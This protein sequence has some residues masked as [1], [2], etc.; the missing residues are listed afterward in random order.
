MDNKQLDLIAKEVS[1]ILSTKK[2]AKGNRAV[3]FVEVIFE[4]MYR[5][6]S[7]VYNNIKLLIILGVIFTI[8][9]GL[10]VFVLYSI[11]ETAVVIKDVV[12]GIQIAINEVI[13]GINIISNTLST[14]ASDVSSAIG[15]GGVNIPTIPKVD[16]L[17]S[18]SFLQTMFKLVTECKS[19]NNV[20]DELM[21]L[22][23]AVSED[24][25]CAYACTTQ[26]IY[27]VQHSI[28][29]IINFLIVNDCTKLISRIF[30]CIIDI[31]MLVLFYIIFIIVKIIVYSSI[32]LLLYIYNYYIYPFINYIRMEILRH[33]KLQHYLQQPSY[34]HTKS[35]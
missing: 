1:I 22:I 6:I 16:F 33:S 14:G 8:L 25:V 26:N 19:R 9:Y 29:K 34:L 18:M 5:F 17:S 10:H 32:P 23:G 21:L 28:N 11:N 12:L 20:I 3:K 30:C 15:E 4:C 7:E 24:K 2:H 35:N 31:D 27:V 13:A